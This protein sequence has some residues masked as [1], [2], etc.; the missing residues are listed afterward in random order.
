MT[1]SSAALE[2]E[3]S[4]SEGSVRAPAVALMSANWR[5]LA[6]ECRLRPSGFSFG[7]LATPVTQMT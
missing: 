3:L 2:M 5:R 6:V 1:D 7:A 4:A